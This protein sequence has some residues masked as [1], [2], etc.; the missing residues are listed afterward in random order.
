MAR[1]GNAIANAYWEARLGNTR[2]PANDDP[3]LESF[4]RQKYANRAFADPEAPWPPPV[5]N[6]DTTSSGVEVAG[7]SGT[8]EQGGGGV[9]ATTTPV[10]EPP[11]LINLLDFDEEYTSSV[12]EGTAIHQQ[13]ASPAA[14]V[15]ALSPVEELMAPTPHIPTAP[16]Q[17]GYASPITHHPTQQHPHHVQQHAQHHAA[18]QQHHGGPL[19]SVLDPWQEPSTAS[20]S[21]ISFHSHTHSPW[22]DLPTRRSMVGPAWGPPPQAYAFEKPVHT[23]GETTVG[24]RGT[25]GYLPPAAAAVSST[26]TMTHGMTT[27]EDVYAGMSCVCVCV[28]FV[29]WVL[30]ANHVRTLR[31][32]AN[33]PQQTHHNKQSP[34]HTVIPESRPTLPPRSPTPQSA[35]P[36]L[37]PSHDP[38]ATDTHHPTNHPSS[39]RFSVDMG[40]TSSS[41]PSTGTPPAALPAAATTTPM[42]STTPPM[43]TPAGAPTGSGGGSGGGSDL[44]DRLQWHGLQSFMTDA[45]KPQPLA[46]VLGRAP[47]TKSV[48]MREAKQQQ[49]QQGP[50]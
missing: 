14:A 46:P 25:A 9:V 42:T 19:S 31:I 34:P 6:A 2:K 1:L 49:Q 50:W 48:S 29:C 36:P 40:K 21:T 37:G 10:Q 43:T 30:Y 32:T 35:H 16:H 23:A 18:Q 4:I 11:P 26:S 22:E 38:W 17:P 41:T 15:V 33:T 3:Y 39:L 20:Y 47:V 45:N 7:G 13:E 12:P 8:V 24:M 5:D 28:Y 27:H 44:L